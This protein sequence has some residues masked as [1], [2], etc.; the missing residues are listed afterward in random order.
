[1]SCSLGHPWLDIIVYAQVEASWQRNGVQ[2]WWETL[3]FKLI[4]TVDWTVKH[5]SKN[6]RTFFS[7]SRLPLSRFDRRLLYDTLGYQV[8]SV[9]SS[10]KLLWE[11]F[12]SLFVA[13]GF[14]LI[15][16]CLNA[17]WLKRG[18]AKFKNRGYESQSELLLWFWN[19]SFCC[20]NTKSSG[21][22]PW[23]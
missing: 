13:W 15:Q 7:S 22:N 9:K 14:V 17:Y 16:K 1:M 23:K 21:K 11:M 12:V 3:R 2:R 18:G 4:G 20:L 6:R 10:E 5:K 8:K 19:Q